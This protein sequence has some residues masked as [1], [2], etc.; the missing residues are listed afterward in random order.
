MGG[1]PAETTFER[2]GLEQLV[3]Q[4]VEAGT[5][6]GGHYATKRP[7]TVRVEHMILGVLR[8]DVPRVR[9]FAQLALLAVDEEYRS[10]RV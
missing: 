9:D 10:L 2:R 8:G 1:V 6:R 5:V 7:A 3:R 4:E